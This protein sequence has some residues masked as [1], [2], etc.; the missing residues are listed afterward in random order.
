MSR[1]RSRKRRPRGGRGV[2]RDGAPRTQGDG[3]RPAQDREA[4]EQVNGRA[5][6]ATA[7]PASRSSETRDRSKIG[8]HSSPSAP[9]FGEPPR[10]PWH[11]L[12]LSELLILAGAIATVIGMKRLGHGLTNGGPTLLVGLAVVAIG[13]IEVTLREHRSGYR[14]HTTLLALAPVVVF[15]SL[16]VLG[17]SVFV[18]PSRLMIVGLLAVDVALFVLLYRALR[19]RFVEARHARV[20]GHG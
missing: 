8:Q 12:P 2:Q 11:P 1:A 16:A 7:R 19:A 14:S 15:D 17:V 5:R 3:E 9:T 6:G 10:A 13:T 18:T 4:P 20:L